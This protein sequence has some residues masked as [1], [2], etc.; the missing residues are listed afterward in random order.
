MQG[1]TTLS[2][3]DQIYAYF[4]LSES[5]FLTLSQ[6]GKANSMKEIV[7]KQRPVTLILANGLPYNHKGKNRPGKWSVRQIHRKYYSSCNIP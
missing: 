5:G 3:I 1:L 6:Q 7:G 2:D 4:T